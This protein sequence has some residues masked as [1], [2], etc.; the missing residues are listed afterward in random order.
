MHPFR[1][2]FLMQKNNT[3]TKYLIINSYYYIIYLMNSY[4]MALSTYYKDRVYR[5]QAES[6]WARLFTELRLPFSYEPKTFEL[7]NGTIYNPDFYFPQSDKYVEIKNYLGS[8]PIETKVKDAEKINTLARCLGKN[9]LLI[10]GRPASAIAYVFDGSLHESEHIDS[11]REIAV[12]QINTSGN[13]LG[14]L[15]EIIQPSDDGSQLALPRNFKF[16][17]TQ[18]VKNLSIP[19]NFDYS[20]QRPATEAELARQNVLITS[21]EAIKLTEPR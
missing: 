20:L 8:T 1:G 19:P 17:I 9:A 16:G 12:R 4:S 6:M 2:M 14:I 5:S 21:R 7:P 3:Q 10:D 18:R 11:I 13:P 15:H